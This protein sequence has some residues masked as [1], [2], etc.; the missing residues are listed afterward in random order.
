M[1][2]TYDKIAT[3]T[4]SSATASIN[5]TSIASSWTDLRLVMIYAG[6]TTAYATFRFNSDSGTNYSWTEMSGAGAS[7]SSG[8]ITNAGS[9]YGS[10]GL[11]NPSMWTL[12]IFSY[13]GSTYKTALVNEIADANGAAAGGIAPK[14]ALW[15]STAAI[16]SV[17]IIAQF[18]S[19]NTFG[20]GTTATLYGILKA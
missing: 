2:T 15:R 17:N 16:T 1:A 4:L 20:A 8:R 11:Y 18:G 12:D 5:F 3:T 6:S 19:P 9:I 14:V 13:A 7:A 10:L